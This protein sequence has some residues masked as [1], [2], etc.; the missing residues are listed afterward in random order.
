[1]AEA[2]F[3]PRWG[4]YAT[5]DPLGAGGDF[6]T[7]PEVSQVFGEL[8]GLWCADLWQRMGA[9]DPVILAELGPGRGTLLADALRAARVAPDFARALRLHLVERSPVL[10]GASRDARAM[11]APTWHDAS[12]S[13]PPGPLL[14]IANEFVDALPVRQFARGKDAWHE[15]RVGLAADGALG[16]HPRS[17]A[18]SSASFRRP[19]RGQRVRDPAGG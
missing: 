19:R 16:L 9:P 3:H 11:R 17:R 14:L 5:R 8:I 2:L 18:G 12:S 6:I 4:Y 7:A 15:R 10:R 13:L 1:M